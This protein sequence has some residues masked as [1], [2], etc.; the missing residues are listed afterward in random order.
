MTV[1]SVVKANKDGVTVNANGK[2][3][4][5]SWAD[6][7]SAASQSDKDLRSVY[8]ELLAEAKRFAQV[9][10]TLTVTINNRTNT[11]HG[12][13]AELYDTAGEFVSG[14]IVAADFGL[15]GTY[16]H[17]MRDAKTAIE[18]LSKR[19]YTVTIG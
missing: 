12:H 13:E 6:L 19:G 16:G 9:E 4:V 1:I 15:A 14:R 3:Q 7:R 5:L 10:K 11:P 2:R 18:K 17:A 8:G